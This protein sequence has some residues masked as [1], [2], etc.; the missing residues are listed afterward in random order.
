MSVKVNMSGA[1]A[2]ISSICQNKQLGQFLASEAAVGMD[3]YV[4]MRT[5]AL[6]W[7]VSVEAFKVHYNAPY[8][9]Y[10]YHGRGMRFTKDYH[11]NATSYWDRAYAI[12]HGQQLGDAGT[13]FLR[14]MS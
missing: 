12:A 10:P 7:S 8:A 3:K 13:E 5:G 6:S 9:T 14:R 2:K 11:P 1:K 4:P